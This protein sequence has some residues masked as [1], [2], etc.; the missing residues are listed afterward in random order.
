MICKKCRTAREKMYK[1]AST[2]GFNIRVRDVSKGR[3]KHVDRKASEEEKE[4]YLENYGEGK[5]FIGHTDCGCKAGWEAGIVLDPFMGSGTTALVAER[6]GRRWI[7]IE[8]NSEYISIADRRLT[9]TQNF[10]QR[11]AV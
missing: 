3:I 10:L 8:L 11:L 4:S 2:Q 6:L 5:Q 9:Q 1:G 7:G